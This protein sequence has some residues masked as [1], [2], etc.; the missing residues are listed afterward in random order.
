MAFSGSAGSVTV[1]NFALRDTVPNTD[2]TDKKDSSMAFN[3]VD[4]HSATFRFAE[5]DTIPSDTD[6]TAKDTSLVLA[7]Q[8]DRIS[9]SSRF[10]TNSDKPAFSI[11]RETAA[12]LKRKTIA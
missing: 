7:Q 6:T 8:T 4:Q 11:K 10:F 9:M 1:F 3:Y 2:S 12:D 5:R